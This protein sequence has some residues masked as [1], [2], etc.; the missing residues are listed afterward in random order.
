MSFLAHL[1][2]TGYSI[3]KLEVLLRELK[4]NGLTGI[5][6]YYPEYTSE[7]ISQYRALAQKLSLALSGGSDYHADMKPHIEIGVG[8]GDLRIPYYVLENIK[9][10]KDK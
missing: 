6:G 9:R 10:I 1:N 8:T 4:E 3:E 5:E 2:Q 7:H